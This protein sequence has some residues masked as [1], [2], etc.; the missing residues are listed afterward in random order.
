[1]VTVESVEFSDV[2]KDTLSPSPSPSAP[3][4]SR[5]PEGS[6]FSRHL[7]T[8]HKSGRI[9]LEW[10]NLNLHVLSKDPTRSTFFKKVMKNKR[11]LRSLYGKAVSG[12]LLAIMG[13]TG[14]I[15]SMELISAVLIIIT[16]LNFL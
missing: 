13:P 5:G 12:E 1:M 7:S 6:S 14:T 16:S 4:P 9:S 2:H 11:I 8:K 10:E 3:S 15:V